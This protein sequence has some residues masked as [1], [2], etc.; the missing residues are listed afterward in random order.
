MRE[1]SPRIAWRALTSVGIVMVLGAC[2]KPVDVRPFLEDG[3]VQEIIE[4]TK[5]AVKVD[6]KTSHGGLVGRDKR[7]E[8]LKSD[9]YYMIEKEINADGVPVP[10]YNNNLPYP[11]YVTDDPIAQI[12]GGLWGELEFITRI[13]DGRINGLTNFHTYTV[14]DARFLSGSLRY[15]DDSTTAKSV[16][17]TGGTGTLTIKSIDGG[18]FL[19]F[20][21][22]FSTRSYEVMAIFI[23]GTGTSTPPNVWPSVISSW[24]QF[25]LEGPNTEVDY[26][27]VNTGDPSDF[28]FLKV[29]IGESITP[30]TVTLNIEF[31]GDKAEFDPDN[32]TFSQSN[33]YNGTP[34]SVTI[35]VSNLNASGYNVVKWQYDGKSTSLGTGQSIILNNNSDIDYFALGTHTITLI[36]TKDGKPYSADFTLT[37]EP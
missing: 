37:V 31:K 10:E 1:L 9:K 25:P 12:P 35:N 5:V 33:Y 34:Q 11:V 8:G 23:S 14:R 29:K 28:K 24:S 32:Y 16:S 21:D 36:C 6:D 17:I 26:V 13:K 30:V 3:T 2:M 20:S 19:D 22:V 4:S 7:I 27:F 18:G 15:T